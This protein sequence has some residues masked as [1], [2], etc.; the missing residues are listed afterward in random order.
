MSGWLATGPRVLA[1]ELVARG[2]RLTRATQRMTCDLSELR[3]PGEWASREP[4]WPLRLQSADRPAADLVSAWRAAYPPGHADYRA[5]YADP[6][7]VL[8][9]LEGLVAG[10]SFGPL[11]PL[12]GLICDGG[13]VVAGLLVND[14]PGEAPWG[15]LLI[16]DLFRHPSYPSTGTLLLR[17][18]L[19]RA[20]L[21]GA[22]V[23]G[24]VVTDGNPV[25][26]L[27]ERHGFTV[28]ERP[29]TVA[30]P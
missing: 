11:S 14:L 5:E 23:L 8:D 3:P 1:D 24:L 27:Y 19:A 10:T 9:R 28:F 7:V 13:A 2:A 20:A 12:S 21:A 30:I 16:T 17:R 6:D 25:H 26:R 18:T 15:G 22:S 4:D 29:A